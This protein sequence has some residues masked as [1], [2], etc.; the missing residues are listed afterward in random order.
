MAYVNDVSPLSWDF[1]GF[2]CKPRTISLFLSSVFLSST[3]FPYLSLNQ[4]PT[5]S[6]LQVSLDPAGAGPQQNT[7]HMSLQNSYFYL[8]ECSNKSL[9]FCWLSLEVV[10]ESI[11]IELI[12]H[13]PRLAYFA[14]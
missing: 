11:L 8:L 1:I 12:S 3:F 14:I 9:V 5:P 4:S 2:L 6:L 10:D 7:T 13:C